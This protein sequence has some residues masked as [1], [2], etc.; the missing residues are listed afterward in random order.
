MKKNELYS[1]LDRTIGFINSCDSKVSIYL[2]TLGVLITVFLSE[3]NI[4]TI[5]SIFNGIKNNFS[6]FSKGYSI[7]V[8]LSL[9]SLIIGVALLV[10]VLV[11]RTKIDSYDK[12]LI[13][14]D[15]IIFFDKISNKKY[16]DFSRIIDNV[17]DEQ[18]IEDIKSQIFINSKICSKKF[19]LQ[20]Y[21]LLIASLAVV[22]ILILYIIGIHVYM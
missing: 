13:K 8:I 16:K 10:S 19:K 6:T 2:A 18:I 12:E 21:G 4:K 11:P 9:I 14:D 3:D 1:N 5:N 15:S 20:R 7:V 22:L 17:T